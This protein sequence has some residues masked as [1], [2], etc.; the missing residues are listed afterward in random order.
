MTPDRYRR[1][2]DV[3]DA[4]QANL[5]VVTDKVHKSH[6]LAAIIRSCDAFG[7][8]EIHCVSPEGGFSNHAGTAMGSQKWVYPKIYNQIIEPVELLSKQGF[9]ILAAHKSESAIDYRSVDYTKPTAILL[10]TEKFGVSEEA[11]NLVT[12]HIFIDMKG[13]VESFNVS[14]AV[15]IILAEAQKQRQFSKRK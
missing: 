8:P 1:I 14:V 9:Q 13:M 6:N 5:T 2:C 3:L 12:Q 7:I 11:Q 15:A 10:G 4:R